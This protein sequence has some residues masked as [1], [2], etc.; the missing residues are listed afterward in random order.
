MVY[1]FALIDRIN[2]GAAY[3]AGMGVDLVRSARYPSEQLTHVSN[4]IE[5]AHWTAFQHRQL[6]VLRT[7]H[8]LVRS[9]LPPLPISLT[10]FTRQLPG[11]LV[12]R[13]FGVRN[14]LTFIV[15]SWGAVQLGMGF[16]KSWGLL[17][18]CRVLLGIF[19]VKR[20]PIVFQ[21]LLV[22]QLRR[23]PFSLHYSSSSPLGGSSI[24]STLRT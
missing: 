20:C 22:N 9:G 16:V 7:L 17:V 11:N 23:L 6:H 12:L 19:E 8:S 1:S 2:M 24:W 5:T 21:G 10:S 18:F 15:F 4:P 3:T 14:W 13:T